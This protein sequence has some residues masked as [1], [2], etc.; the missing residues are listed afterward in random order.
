MR[1]QLPNLEAAGSNPAGVT[2]AD[3]ARGRHQ[4][5]TKCQ[6]QTWITTCHWIFV[7]ILAN[8]VLNA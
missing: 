5:L 7:Y 8:A 1:G 4:C 6:L 3:I 2:K